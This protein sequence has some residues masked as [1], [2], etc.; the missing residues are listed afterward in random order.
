MK[1]LETVL[2]TSDREHL[3]KI[4]NS[5]IS[6]TPTG[7]DTVAKAQRFLKFRTMIDEKSGPVFQK[8]SMIERERLLS[9]LVWR[10]TCYVDNSSTAVLGTTTYELGDG[11][12]ANQFVKEDKT[13]WC[14]VAKK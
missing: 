4:L 9:E 2:V 14:L 10:V 1:K 7:L 12:I 8:L 5:S 11:F 3:K 13:Y 6:L